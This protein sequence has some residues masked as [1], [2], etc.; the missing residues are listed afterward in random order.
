MLKE[1]MEDNSP[2]VI[3]ARSAF[4]VLAAL[5]MIVITADV[6]WQRM[7]GKGARPYGE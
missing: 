7:R 5:G 4:G 6:F 2:A 3:K 1:P